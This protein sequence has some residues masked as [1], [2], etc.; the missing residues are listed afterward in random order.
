MNYDTI[1][2]HYLESLLDGNRIG[3]REVL[4]EALKTGI[5][6]NSIYTELFWP[7]MTQIDK[8][9]RGN[10]IDQI[11]ENMATRINR[12]LVDQLQSKLPRRELRDLKMI[13]VCAKDEPEELGAQMCADLFESDGW[14][15]KFLGGGIPND[16]IIALVGREQ[17]D[18]L[19]IYGTKPS[20][21][22][23]V[24]R[25]IDLLRDI[26][27]CPKMRVMVSGGVF[28]RAEGLWEEIGAD[29][30][31]ATAKEALTIA[32]TDQYNERPAKQR[33]QR[34]S[35]GIEQVEEAV[36]V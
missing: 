7:V 12:T 32:L 30:F 21:A 35:I 22:P 15:V 23:D 34:K 2:A 3:C 4:G 8:L 6:A 28:N 16:E 17:P 36:P 24:R 10:R 18:R 14:E 13:M 20:G 29:M 9:F 25:L 26:A 33:R 11:T 5:P 31:A 27:A 1:I 19:F